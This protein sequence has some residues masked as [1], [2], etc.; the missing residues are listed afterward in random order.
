M[1]CKNKFHHNHPIN[2]WIIDTVATDHM[3]TSLSLLSNVSSLKNCSIHL[4]DGFL[5][6]ITHTGIV[7]ISDSLILCDVLCVPAFFI[8]SVLCK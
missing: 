1:S 8:K 5:I 4:P 3:V 2:F 7:K 6:P